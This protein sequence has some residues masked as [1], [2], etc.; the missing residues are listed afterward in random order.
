MTDMFL[1][2]STCLLQLVVASAGKSQKKK[3]FE[4]R[5]KS[6]SDQIF[7]NIIGLKNDVSISIFLFFLLF[8]LNRAAKASN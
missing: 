8:F 6:S 7:T 1:L 4:K 3:T 2:F 5:E